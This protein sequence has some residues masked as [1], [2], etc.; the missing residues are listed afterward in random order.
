LKDLIITASP[1]KGW[2]VKMLFDS[3][4]ARIGGCP[5]SYSLSE[6]NHAVESINGNYIDC[7]V[8]G[9]YLVCPMTASG[10]R[11]N[12]NCGNSN[13]GSIN[14]TPTNGLPPYSYQW[15]NGATTQ[16]IAS[17]GAGTYTVTIKDFS[18][19]NG[20]T[21]PVV[22][23]F[24][25]TQ[26]DPLIVNI[27]YNPILCNGQSTAVNVAG[28]GGTGT[29]S[30]TG[31]FNLNAGTYTYTI[32]DANGCNA[33]STFTIPEPTALV[34][35][36]SATPIACNGG[37]STVTINANGGTLP[38]AGTG[39]YTVNAGNYS[40]NVTD[41]NG[42]TSTQ[43]V[44][45][46]QP[47]LLSAT[48]AG[49]PIACYGGNTVVTVNANGGTAPYTG[50]GNFT[51]V[52]GN[53]SYNV[54]DFNGC[55]TIATLN[56]AQPSALQ[57][58]GNTTSILCNGGTNGSITL[59]VSGGTAPYSYLW[60]NGAI[61]KDISGV[62]GGAYNV[63][64]TDASGCTTLSSFT[65]TQPSTLS[66]T[67]SSTNISCFGGANGTASISANGGT[68]PYTYSWNVSGS[69]SSLAGLTAGNY[70]VN[71]T[72]ANGCTTSATYT[73][74]QPTALAV[75]ITKV[76]VFCNGGHN[77]RATATP[78]GGTAPY[79]YLWST[80]A[81][82]AM[83]TG[84]PQGNYTVTVTDANGCSKSGIICITQPARISITP[85][86]TNVSCFGGSNGTASAVVSGGTPAYTYLWSTGG[87]TNSISGLSNGSYTLTVT[88]AKSCTSTKTVSI[89]QPTALSISI[90]STNV[91]CN[92][93]SNGS[94]SA[95]LSGGTAP[96][97]YAW[98]NSNSTANNN[99]L[100]AGTYSLTVTDANGCTN[101]TT[102]T[103]S[104]PTTLSAS[105]S[106]TEVSCN[107]G[108]NG[109]ASVTATS[110]TAPY[111]YLWSNGNGTSS[112]T[113]L[114]AGTYNVTVTD[115]N[116]C[117]ISIS[118]IVTEP[119]SLTATT[120][121]TNVLCNGGTTNNGIYFYEDFDDCNL[122]NFT[123]SGGS[124]GI[125][126]SSYQGS[127]A[128]SMTH[129]AG[130]Q[131][132]NFYP[133]GLDFDYGTYKV[134]ARATAFISDNY[135][136]LFQ[137]SNL[138]GGLTIASLPNNTDNPGFYVNGL[139]INYGTT[140]SNV[141]QGQWYEM[142]VE[143][144]PSIINVYIDGSLRFSTTTFT[145]PTSGKFKLGVAF[146][147]TYDNM[148]FIPYGNS[149]NLGSIYISASGGTVPYSGTG[150]F[151]V[152][153]GTY[154]YIV[155]DANGCSASTSATVTEPT[156]LTASTNVT[157]VLCNGGNGSVQVS[158]NGGTAPYTGT[159]SYTVTAGTYNYTV[160]DA[161]GC[162]ALTSATVTEPT[163][164]TASTNQTNVSCY[165]GNNGSASVYATGGT[166]PYT[167][168]WSNTDNTSTTNNLSAGTYSVNVTD[169]NGCTYST[170]ATITEPT[171][172]TSSATS[173]DVTC[174][175][176]NDG[177]AN[178]TANGGTAPYTYEWNTGDLTASISN[179]TAGTYTATVTDANGCT[180][181]SS[182]TINQGPQLV[183]T[184]SITKPLCNG[185]S[186][187][188]A[189]VAVNGGTA[190][191]TYSWT[192]N[193][194]TTNAISNVA[195]GTYTV[196]VTDANGC[197]GSSNVQVT[198]PAPITV[199]F[200][201]TPVTCH[202]GNDGSAIATA[203]GGTAPYTYRWACG[204]NGPDLTGRT[205]GLYTLVVTDA[206]G[207][208]GTF[209]T[210]ITEP[211]PITLIVNQI[212]VSCKNGSNGAI[213]I[214][215]TNGGTGSYSYL[216][217]TGSTSTMISGI[218]V[219]NYTVTVTD[220][221]GCT[222]Q[223]YYTIS[224]PLALSAYFTKV[225]VK[226]N[227]GA[228]GS[229]RVFAN[230][231]TAPYTYLWSTGATTVNITGRT[232]G[233]YS[234]TITDANGCTLFKR[235]TITQPAPIVISNTVTNVSCNGYADGAI[236]TTVTGGCVPYTYLWSNAATSASI[237]NLTAGSYT[238]TV[239]DKNLCT[240]TKTVTVSQPT[241]L[242]ASVTSTNVS[243]NGGNDGSAVVIATGGT[244]PYS[245]SWNNG[246]GI[247]SNNNLAAGTY[248][249]TIT[250][251]NGCTTTTNVTITEPSELAATTNNT[252]VL[253]NGGNNGS[254]SVNVTGGTAPYTYSW[255]NGNQTSTSNNLTAGTYQVTI[256]D[257]NGCTLSKSVNV[258]QPTAL[259]ASVSSTNVS[260]NGGNNGSATVTAVGGTAPYSYNWSNVCATTS[261][262]NLT[263]GTYTVVVSDANGCSYTTSVTITEP[264]VLTLTTS[265]TNVL[266][267]GGSDGSASVTANGGT[268]PY[269]YAW[270]NQS[271]TANAS[272]LSA[273]SYSVVVTDANNCS[274]TASVTITQPTSLTLSFTTANV[275][276][277]GGN[278]GS[279]TANVN[280]GTAPYSYAWSNGSST[281]TINNLIAG[282]Y[283]VTIT[284]A[285]GCSIISN[286]PISNTILERYSN[287]E[288]KF[289]PAP[290][291]WNTTT[292]G[293]STGD[294]PFGNVTAGSQAAA[295][296]NSLFNYNTYWPADV[297]DGMDLFVRRTIDLSDYDLN[298]INWFLGVD[299]GYALYINGHCVSSGNAEGYTF[300]WEYSG[301]V[302]SQY[303]V[304]GNNLVAVALEDH[305][306]LTAFDMKI[307]GT[308]NATSS[309]SVVITEP[310][311]LTATTTTTNVLCNGGNGTVNVNAN[312]GT[313]PYSG[314]GSFTVAAGTYSYTVT[315]ANGCTATTTAIV[316]APAALTISMSN[317]NVSCNSG[318]NGTAT[319]TVNGGVAPYTYVWSNSALTSTVTGLTAGTYSV[320]AT[321]A[322]G[323]TITSSVTITQ[324]TAL[325]Q[326]TTSTNVTCNGGDNGTGTI[327]VTGGTS[328]YTY[329]WSN[330]NTNAF[331]NGLPAGS[332]SVTATDANGC[333][334]I[335]RATIT[336][337]AAIAITINRT[338]ITCF[339][340]SNGSASASVTGG[341]APYTYQWSSS[342]TT[343]S[344]S[345]KTAGN[346]TVTVTDA[347]G[348]TMSKIVCIIQN[349]QITANAAINHVTCNAGTNGSAVLT[350]SGGT[351]PY[352]YAWVGGGAGNS[353]TNK[354]A[355]I[356]NVLITDVNGCTNYKCVI[357]T[358]PTA[359]GL[360]TT[361]TNAINGT[362]ATGTA[363]V[364]A[365]GGTGAYTYLW[366]SGEITTSISN[367][368]PGTYT[369]TVT[370]ANGCTATATV[371]ISTNGS[372]SLTTS[373]VNLT[374]N[375]GTNGSCSVSAT[376]GNGT[377]TY[378]WSTG[379]T[380]SSISNRA[381]GT[382]TVTVTDG[383]GT[384][385][386]TT[387]TLT[388]PAAVTVNGT[389]TNIT[390]N[391][392]TNGGVVTTVNGG[393]GSYTYLWSDLSTAST[394]SNKS[395]GCY[396]VTVTDQNGCTGSKAFI[397][398]QPAPIVIN[399]TT[400]TT[401]IGNCSGTATAT[402]SGGFVSPLTYLW[403]TSSTTNVASGLCANATATVTVTDGN[404]CS[405]SRTSSL[406][407]CG[408]S[409]SRTNG[410]TLTI[411]EVFPVPCNDQLSVVLNGESNDEFV[412]TIMDIEGRILTQQTHVLG[413]TKDILSI[414]TM[415]LAS[416]VA[417]ISIEKGGEKA[418]SR[419]IIQH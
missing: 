301:I 266:C 244:A 260:C 22:L 117:T 254:A 413:S 32:T 70:S 397:L 46:T 150:S 77:G 203:S 128:A 173:N 229:A 354:P 411:S 73:L 351:A 49:A 158:A 384:N 83:I 374:C 388:Q 169:A 163:A 124:I 409:T 315:D 62:S 383:T 81:T 243:C 357:I 366:S 99:T 109:T 39:N 287:Y 104:E 273:G 64:I 274:A 161:N 21:A 308:P 129:F 45:V 380:T 58:T 331:A 181:T 41:A 391:G 168:S 318:A 209:S 55:T 66:A 395:A 224:Q 182:V 400:T 236:A 370:D 280:G 101:T 310:T 295:Q 332:Y 10:N 192:S 151:S 140:N 376:G 333:T 210:T 398:T 134:M 298:S 48:A 320:V 171:L 65:I 281:A 146:S 112:I 339:G 5:S 373:Q 115:A 381:A 416:Q 218:P 405:K 197:I 253:C 15:S 86:T 149:N 252:D 80:G 264:A 131:P 313:A 300:E 338:T 352:T 410:S 418:T 216:W 272:N 120:S 177:F 261:N 68:T 92:G 118:A 175:G 258:G 408:T 329:L 194:S 361:K 257:A 379:A 214:T 156:L 242:N 37:N 107:G 369:V 20:F 372:I 340:G 294:A 18:S 323:C 61:T 111:S 251:A 74:T 402:V 231:G 179:I 283:S 282:T 12:A 284:D 142:K 344:I 155:T 377:Y 348:C 72:D 296:Y 220:A 367:K 11:L 387:V 188:S 246:C 201:P 363:T 190:P 85:S 341:V 71:V 8:T 362:S 396:T 325:Q 233:L 63:T 346:Y 88:D 52:S 127:C 144:F 132:N 4:N 286:N 212:N 119:T 245:Y 78:S 90:T 152:T 7:N 249:V 277:N 33:A 267:N 27:D 312:G 322:N 401:S 247:T 170:S 360:T 248:S 178:V 174:Y 172:L 30:G 290:S 176:G 415:N 297:A 326:N 311:L 262:N 302:P 153:A 193:P 43:A 237:S 110:G 392:G 40:Y 345:N 180:A 359:I 328:P 207:C 57:A 255:S 125:T 79:T 417:I 166:A 304:Q 271:G 84:R 35:S 259:T 399:I 135:M 275:T 9:N 195:A 59:T 307:T 350:T 206:N 263:A 223:A 256:T 314:T 303:L 114:L 28:F 34:T 222:Y 412:V 270:S 365:T 2:T 230:G 278:N 288:Y 393:S 289:A 234:V 309:N 47:S 108:N 356:Y 133:T 404:G 24:T 319:A 390:C 102:V 335:G 364:S 160:T 139:G 375:G 130:Q 205:A 269:T 198:E 327:T 268:A 56:V 202:G 389:K 87:N 403:S 91:S 116:G 334:I 305:G 414:N 29:I 191:F 355:G 103:I 98:N 337:P 349:A 105:T 215:S 299:N 238:I 321:D 143:V 1:F 44:G 36:S 122:S 154:S 19:A 265:S 292:G 227:G 17:L 336:Q 276:C 213:N 137:G 67:S 316:T 378:L 317:T 184:S 96:Y 94:A 106:M 386:A 121:T 241:Q 394:I 419:I 157:N 291:G 285:N 200:T 145:T 187:G 226:C 204:I 54:V 89:S 97:T 16:N 13:T 189:T 26:P 196:N 385:N 185:G 42:C 279:A 186:E 221:K 136:Y 165:G 211:N 306:V 167:Y 232:A 208:T 95:S 113:N 343:S 147:G 93:G 51:E 225:N 141:T 50:T 126:N 330:G 23:S 75:H 183:I 100:S 219:G 53:Y 382:Y 123:Y 69:G 3:A 342:E 199:V 76:N 368:L 235:V 358:Q 162:S 293:W 148:E 38:Y 324:P 82:T 217:S 250:D 347:N 228:N 25:V 14:V 371:T 138:T 407:N 239:Q 164:L 240:A 6:F 353:I 31:L 406:I 159:G 60:S